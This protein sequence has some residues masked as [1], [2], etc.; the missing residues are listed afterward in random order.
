MK[1]QKILDDLKQRIPELEIK[2][3]RDG[4]NPR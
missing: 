1:E 4:L 3:E 2:R